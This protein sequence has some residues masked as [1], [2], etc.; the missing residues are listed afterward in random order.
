MNNNYSIFTGE[1]NALLV[2][3]S[4][5]DYAVQVTQNGCIDTSAC[6]N[7]ITIGIDENSFGKNLLVY[8]NPTDG[9][10]SIDLGQH[11]QVV[12]ITITD[13]RGRVVQSNIY[14]QSQLLRLKLEE[15][16]GIYLLKI[17]T[18]NN[19]TVIRLVKK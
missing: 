2:P 5:G 8:P 19:N 3:A 7:I 14:N 15:P 6:V 17:E 11:Y 4:N 1:T 13:L 10:F 16:A 9:N 18:T 12:K